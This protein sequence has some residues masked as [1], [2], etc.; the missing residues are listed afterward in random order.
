MKKVLHTRVYKRTRKSHRKLI[1][2]YRGYFSLEEN[3]PRGWKSLGTPDRAIAEKRIMEFALSAH[4]EQEGLAPPKSIREGGAKS[5]EVLLKGYEAD[6]QSLGRVK[7]HIHNT[8]T[9]IRRIAKETKWRMLS[10]IRPQPFLEWRATLQCSAKTKKDYQISF[11]A[12][13]NWLVETEQLLANP[14]SKISTV[15]TRGKAC[16]YL[17]GH[18]DPLTAHLQYSHTKLDTNAIENAIRPSAIGK[19][20][21]LFVGHPEAGDAPPSCTHYSAPVGVMATTPTNI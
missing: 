17:L 14:L 5:I 9:R 18:W 7:K 3:G 10:D 20:N 11:C 8:V 2:N 21:W 4:R 13:L 1:S 15:E 6:L 19:K 16:T 12:F